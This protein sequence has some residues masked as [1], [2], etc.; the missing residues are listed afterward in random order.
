MILIPIILT[1]F[2]VKIF[3]N[4]EHQ[5]KRANLKGTTTFQCFAM[6]IVSPSI[7]ALL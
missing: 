3:P 2:V 5:K 7:V 1:L 4:A 6:E